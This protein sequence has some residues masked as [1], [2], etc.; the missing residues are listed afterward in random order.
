MTTMSPTTTAT[1]TLTLLLL[2][3]S[4]TLAD[5]ATATARV[6]YIRHGQSQWN[7]EQTAM[8][9]SGLSD[10]AI[11]KIGDE[12]RFVDSP[13]SARGVNEALTLQRNLTLTPDAPWYTLGGVARCALAR[14]CEPLLLTSNLR[15]AID[16]TLLGLRPI[17]ESAVDYG[18]YRV[19]VLPALQ[20]TCGHADCVPTARGADG[21]FATPSSRD[22]DDDADGADEP[23]R[24]VL[25]AQAHAREQAALE[26]AAAVA[27]A[28]DGSNDGVDGVLL[29]AEARA[30]AAAAAMKAQADTASFL[31]GA[32]AT[33]LRVAPHEIWDDR[34]NLP[35]GRATLEAAPHVGDGA[36]SAPFLARLGEVLSATLWEPLPSGGGDAAVVH[37]GR[38]KKGARDAERRVVFGAHSR[39]LRDLLAAFHIGCTA[40]VRSGPGAAAVPTRLAW[41]APPSNAAACADLSR[42]DTRM[43]NAGAVRW[44]LSLEAPDAPG[45]L[46][47]LTLHGCRLDDGGAVLPRRPK[48]APAGADGGG[49]FPSAAAAL[50][51]A[52]L[53]FLTA[54][55]W[56]R[57][58]RSKVD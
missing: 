47:T 29:A 53:A 23:L 2:A 24:T 52:S 10:A 11:K 12:E 48:A 9:K 38:G 42:E 33:A 4:R 57:R 56:R 14:T 31:D 27:P 30:T 20:E 26:M 32:Y 16:T 49:D 45:A 18:L 13:L 6:Y 50:T 22:D 54:L 41:S 7:A 34:R 46:P 35:E 5:G 15:R 17:L 1:L 58:A 28:L 36:A 44:Q 39:L 8:R 25:A 19:L 21:A 43:A 37:P 51:V 40:P 55:V 3:P